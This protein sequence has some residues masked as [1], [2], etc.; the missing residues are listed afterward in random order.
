LNAV[1]KMFRMHAT[2]A[3]LLLAGVMA[4]AQAVTPPRFYGATHCEPHEIS[5][6]EIERLRSAATEQS[7]SAPDMQT[8]RY[9]QQPHKLLASMEAG[10]RQLEDGTE[11]WRYY[12]CERRRGGFHD[13]ECTWFDLRGVRRSVL[14]GVPPLRFVIPEPLP[15]PEA[16]AAID[17]AYSF[18]DK[19]DASTACPTVQR[20]PEKLAEFRGQMADPELPHLVSTYVGGPILVEGEFMQMQ[21]ERGD[22]A[23]GAPRLVCWGPIEYGP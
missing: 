6:R 3:T 19:L 11:R 12:Q 5:Q 21:V 8:L 16:I 14:A 2:I 7:A 22:A 10:H 1:G 17:L 15:T 20:V 18:Y 23:K 9:C 4:Q 13:W